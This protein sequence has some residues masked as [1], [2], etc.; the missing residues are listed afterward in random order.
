[1]NDAR[2]ECGDELGL[3]GVGWTGGAVETTAGVGGVGSVELGSIGAGVGVGG[4]GLGAGTT[5]G[6]GTASSGA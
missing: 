3:D 4:T 5:G 1:M 6:D 2:R